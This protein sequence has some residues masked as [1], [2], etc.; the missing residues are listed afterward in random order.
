MERTI[1]AAAVFAKRA[2]GGKF[3]AQGQTA[4]L[5][6]FQAAGVLGGLGTGAALLATNPMLASKA[7]LGALAVPG[8]PWAMSRLSTSPKIAKFLAKPKSAPT[9]LEALLSGSLAAGN[10]N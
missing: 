10:A 3:P 4:I 6:Y 2:G 9:E 7:F 1:E 8:I 5:P